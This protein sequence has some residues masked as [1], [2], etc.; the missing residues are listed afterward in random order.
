MEVS[1]RSSELCRSLLESGQRQWAGWGGQEG[2]GGELTAARGEYAQPRRRA[3]AHLAEGPDSC[4][5][6]ASAEPVADPGWSQ[7]PGVAGAFRQLGWSQSLG[8]A[9]ANWVASAAG[10]SRPAWLALP[11]AMCA[12]SCADDGAVHGKV[13][14]GGVQREEPLLPPCAKRWRRGVLR[15]PGELA[16]RGGSAS[17]P[18]VEIMEAVAEEHEVEQ[19]DLD[20]ARAEWEHF[21]R[22]ED[23]EDCAEEEMGHDPEADE[24]ELSAWRREVN[25]RAER[26]A[27][28][29]AEQERLEGLSSVSEGPRA[30][31]EAS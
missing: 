29:R 28:Q 5:A 11:G 21:I 24:V 1:T 14:R 18:E 10:A 17:M 7:G 22:P 2:E 13:L 16:Q 9:G 27:Q 12:A 3:Q 8:L 15:V 23:E 26:W 20:N 6:P 19:A 30:G 25:E 4:E 31:P